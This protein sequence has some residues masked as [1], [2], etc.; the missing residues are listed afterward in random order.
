[1]DPAARVGKITGMLLEM[2]LDEIVPLLFF[3]DIVRST[4]PKPTALRAHSPTR[5][6]ARG[7]L[8]LL[9]KVKEAQGV[10]GLAHADDDRSNSPDPNPCAESADDFEARAHLHTIL[11]PHPT[12]RQDTA[13]L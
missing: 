9:N 7:L 11:Y 10:L 13:A 2:D 4:S 12:S 1:V 8:Q 5:P 6:V 3:P